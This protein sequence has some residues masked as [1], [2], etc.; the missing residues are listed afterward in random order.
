[1]CD[2]AEEI[3]KKK[4]GR[5]RK[6][7][8]DPKWKEPPK[9]PTEDEAAKKIMKEKRKAALAE[10]PKAKIEPGDNTKFLNNSLAMWD[11]VQPDM[12][13]PVAV[14]GR[15]KEYFQLCADSD[16][17][18]SVAGFSFA[19]GVSRKTMWAWIAG[20]RN[21]LSTAVID[22][23]KRAYAILN[24]QMEDYMQNGKINPISGIFLMK[25]NM[26]YEDKTEMIVSPNNPIGAD[27]SEDELR[28][29]IEADIIIDQD[30]IEG[31]FSE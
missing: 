20:T 9:P 14:R 28:K 1:M 18:P 29:K 25:N 26:G 4:R 3:V 30:V 31:E 5:P 11:W 10:L 22:E 24:I 8:D 16:M 21:N 23:L 27:M 13:D 15:V 17:R 19:F 12:R 6:N 7:P 2:I